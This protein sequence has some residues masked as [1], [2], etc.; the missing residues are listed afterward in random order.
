MIR[1]V[2]FAYVLALVSSD[3]VI[4]GYPSVPVTRAML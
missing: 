4:P 2:G 3:N 1:A